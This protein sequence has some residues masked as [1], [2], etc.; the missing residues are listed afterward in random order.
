MQKNIFFINVKSAEDMLTWMKKAL[1]ILLKV[2]DK[3]H[4]PH[5]EPPNQ[6]SSKQNGPVIV[7]P[8]PA[9]P[10][11]IRLKVPEDTIPLTQFVQEA[12][13][14]LGTHIA[15]TSL[16][17]KLSESNLHLLEVDGLSS[18]RKA[19]TT[20]SPHHDSIQQAWSQRLNN[21]KH[22]QHDNIVRQITH[23][24]LWDVTKIVLPP[25]PKTRPRA[26]RYPSYI[27]R[28]DPRA[29][30][31]WWDREVLGIKNIVEGM[32]GW[33][34]TENKIYRKEAES[35]H[36]MNG[37]EMNGIQDGEIC[38]FISCAFGKLHSY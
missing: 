13:D 23:I 15:N 32:D 19:E 16:Q 38:R 2:L 29:F 34:R 37:S 12:Q 21:A 7:K 35:I 17:H 27:D 6:P 14:K 25:K 20:T 3:R 18:T 33:V 10:I 31:S 1:Q 4:H 30:L 36:L 24:P 9:K 11:Q 5:A 26:S 8:T 22:D 28:E